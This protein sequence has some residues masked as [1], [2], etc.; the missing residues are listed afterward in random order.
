MACTVAFCLL[1]AAPVGAAPVKGATPSGRAQ[2]VPGE[3]L[4]KMRPGIAVAGAAGG[5]RARD[6]GPVGV[7]GWRLL[8]LPSGLSVDDALARLRG[9]PNVQ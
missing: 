8:K 4:V 1:G 7:R 2:T 9:N 6:A 5:L 3:V